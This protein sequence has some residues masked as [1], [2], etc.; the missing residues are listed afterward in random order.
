MY[1]WLIHAAVW[2]KPTQCCKAIILQFKISKKKKNRYKCVTERWAHR[3]CWW[4]SQDRDWD[5]CMV[6]SSL[7]CH[8]ALLAIVLS[9]GYSQAPYKLW[10]S[11]L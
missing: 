8:T 7:L 11:R 10:H 5:R 6:S 3:Y 2:P 4:W 1:L 9:E